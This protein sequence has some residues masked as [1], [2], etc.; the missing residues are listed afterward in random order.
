MKKEIKYGIISLI[1][2]VV[3]FIAYFSFGTTKSGDIIMPT[4][5]FLDG[6]NVWY[7]LLLT[8]ILEAGIL[9]LALKDSYLKSATMSLCMNAVT[10]IISVATLLIEGFLI[11]ALF[12]FV[13]VGS[14]HISHWIANFI[15]VIIMNACIE[16]LV[17]KCFGH[18][19]NK[20]FLWLCLANLISIMICL[21]C[22]LYWLEDMFI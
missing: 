11:E 21:L 12:V 14:F 8:V 16:G 13:D 3:L 2:L 9:K 17:I 4:I 20:T 18:K 7:V 15:G 5:H 10:S 19:F 22:N 1:S 6:M